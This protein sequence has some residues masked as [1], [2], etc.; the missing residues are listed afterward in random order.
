[1]SNTDRIHKIIRDAVAASTM[2]A[3]EAAREIVRDFALIHKSSLPKVTHANGYIYAG[4]TDAHESKMNGPLAWQQVAE[5]AAIAIHLDAIHAKDAARNKRRD[6]LASE[7]TAVN[8][9]N[10]QLPYT[11]ALINRIIDLESA[12]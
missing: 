4:D 10:G 2:P 3:T 1:M 12:A 6:E 8:S 5:M 9:Y 11:Q 7:F